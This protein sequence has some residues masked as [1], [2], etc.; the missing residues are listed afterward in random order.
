MKLVDLVALCAMLCTTGCEP[1]L[2]LELKRQGEAYEFQLR[3]EAD[4]R[5]FGADSFGVME[6]SSVICEIRHAPGPGTR[7]SRWIYGSRP[8]G[9]SISPRCQS[10]QMDRTYRADGGGRFVGMLVFRLK[11][12]GEVEIMQQGV[13]D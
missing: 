4:G 12:D 11:A 10:L 3:R 1:K 9:Y 2:I 5:G 6:G 13:A 8:D 7:V